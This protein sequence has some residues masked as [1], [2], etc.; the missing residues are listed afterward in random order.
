VRLIFGLS[1]GPAGEIYTRPPLVERSVRATFAHAG[2]PAPP[3]YYQFHEEIMTAIRIPITNYYGGGGYTVPVLVGSRQSPAN[4]ILDTGSC[5]LAVK[6]AAYNPAA[7]TDLRPTS[8]VQDIRYGTGPWA[9]PLVTTSLAIGVAGDNVTITDG[10][11]AL[12]VAREPDNFGLSDGILGLAYDTRNDAYSLAGYLGTRGTNPAVTWPWPLAVRN[13]QSAIEQFERLIG[14]MPHEHVTPYFTQL[15][16]QNL[17]ANKFAFY[18]RRSTTKRNDP[19]D[20]ENLGFFIL[21][22]G[23]EQTDLYLGEFLNVDVVHDAY[24]NTNLSAVKVGD[25]AVIKANKLPE[26]FVDSMMSNSIIDSGTNSL[27]LSDDVFQAIMRSLGTIKPELQ[28]IAQQA[29]QAQNSGG[30]VPNAMVKLGDWPE[31]TF[32]M[33][34]E[35]G[36]DVPLVCSP[37]T[38]WQLDSFDGGTATFQIDA[39]GEAQSILGLPLFNNYF[40][41]FDRSTDVSGVVRFASIKQIEGSGR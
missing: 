17:I 21:G 38:Y 40:T 2:P 34:G 8:L 27:S 10:P 29:T 11:L 14:T 41:V 16:K 26:Q 23:E 6:H 20:P 28:Q 19:N 7:D 22:G 32:I 12:T 25:A 30:G 37:Q 1:R 3:R 39:M 15:V 18:T 24:Y 9:G 13:S 31:I 4:V 36:E 35:Q 5:T 33:A